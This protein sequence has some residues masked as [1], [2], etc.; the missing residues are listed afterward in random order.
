MKQLHQQAR[1]PVC[2]GVCCVCVHLS[3]SLF[4]PFLLALMDSATSK[5]SNIDRVVMKRRLTNQASE[6]KQHREARG[7][8]ECGKNYSQFVI[9]R[10][11]VFTSKAPLI[12][13]IKGMVLTN[14]L[15]KMTNDQYY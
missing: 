1:G 2:R 9:M 3:R 6:H 7:G 4:F 13:R 15:R 14:P 10:V 8:S 5:A 12:K 11:A